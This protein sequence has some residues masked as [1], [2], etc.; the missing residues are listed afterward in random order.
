MAHL[1]FSFVFRQ[2]LSRGPMTQSMSEQEHFNMGPLSLL[3][4]AFRDASALPRYH[5][6][7]AA[8][9]PH[10]LSLCKEPNGDKAD[11]MTDATHQRV[12]VTAG[13]SKPSS[14]VSRLEAH[15]LSSLRNSSSQAPAEDKM[16]G[17]FRRSTDVAY[18]SRHA[19]QY[20]AEVKA[21]GDLHMPGIFAA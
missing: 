17:P 16:G 4:P 19:T 6:G 7:N 15:R 8:P 14:Q 1:F 10:L 13:L 2:C 3:P 11:S 9:H 5:G 12:T 21:Q 20:S 18:D